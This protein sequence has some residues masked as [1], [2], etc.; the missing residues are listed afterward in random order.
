MRHLLTIE[1]HPITALGMNVLIE[2]ILKDV[3]IYQTMTG[4][5]ALK[6][7]KKQVM[8]IIILDPALPKTDTNFLLQELLRIQPK[9]KVLIF[10]NRNEKVFALPFIRIGA[11]GYIVRSAP[12]AEFILAIHNLIAGKLYFNIEQLQT[13]KKNI[14]KNKDEISPFERLSGR[15]LELFTH[16]ITGLRIKEI[17]HIMNIEQSTVA[18]LKKRIMI[19]LGVDNM[20]DLVKLST[21]FNILE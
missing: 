7:L 11:S 10:S 5:D 17:T 16:L 18:T 6:K 3:T 2:E 21:V 19:K 4:S 1:G 13:Q 12:K 14:G 15:E 20:V 8:D 9:V